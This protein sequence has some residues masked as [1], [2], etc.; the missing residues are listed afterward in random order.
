MFAIKKLKDIYVA[1]HTNNL[2]VYMYLH[3][4]P[5]FINTLE[6]LYSWRHR[7]LQLKEIV[8]PAMNIKLVVQYLKN[9][10]NTVN[11]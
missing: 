5:S 10:S 11:N 6:H 9:V 2:S 3:Q 7:Q 8:L 1:K 4:F